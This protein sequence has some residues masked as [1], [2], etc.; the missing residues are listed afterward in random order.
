[1]RT[2]SLK[3]WWRPG[4]NVWTPAEAIDRATSADVDHGTGELELLRAR[5][6]KQ[7]EVIGQIFQCLSQ[8][9]QDRILANHGFEVIPE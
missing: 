7:Q 5:V 8:Y 3:Y 4:P 6:D 9:D 2:Y 1:M